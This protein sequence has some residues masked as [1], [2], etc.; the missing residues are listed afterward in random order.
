M[1]VVIRSTAVAS[2]NMNAQGGT[3]RGR[4]GALGLLSSARAWDIGPK[5]RSSLVRLRRGVVIVG[6]LAGLLGM[7]GFGVE[8][9]MPRPSSD[10]AVMAATSAASGGDGAQGHAAASVA[11]SAHSPGIQ[12][13]H[14]APGPQTDMGQACLAVLA[15]VALVL[16]LVGSVRMRR[17]AGVVAALSRPWATHRGPAPPSPPDL[18]L[19]CVLRI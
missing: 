6:L 1:S 16:L 17:A 3:R 11:A 10:A 19:L 2:G 12:G 8:H 7:H 14:N 15:T 13:D 4:E 18:H 9:G 5:G